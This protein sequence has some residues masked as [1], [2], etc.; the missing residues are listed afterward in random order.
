MGHLPPFDRLRAFLTSPTAAP[1]RRTPAPSRP[2]RV[3]AGNAQPRGPMSP[4]PA[5]AASLPEHLLALCLKPLDNAQE[6]AQA[7]TVSSEWRTVARSDSLWEF[8]YGVGELWGGRQRLWGGPG[9]ACRLR[10]ECRRRSRNLARPSPRC[11]PSPHPGR[12]PAPAPG[13]GGQSL[14]QQLRGLPRR[15]PV[16]PARTGRRPAPGAAAAGWQ[17]QLAR[18]L[19]R[20]R[21]DGGQLAPGPVR[22]AAAAG[23]PRLHSV[24][25]ACRGLTGHVQRLLHAA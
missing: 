1:P 8:R 2:G 20:A 19:P 24:C 18:G 3:H 9:R 12:L 6:L 23:A 25:P 7:A 13:P 5:C 4:P 17:H 22:L 21:R 11:P 10:R 16:L 15:Q 14:R